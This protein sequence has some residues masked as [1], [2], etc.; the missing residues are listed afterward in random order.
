MVKRPISNFYNIITKK[1][2]VVDVYNLTDEHDV[3]CLDMHM[4]SSIILKSVLPKLKNAKKI[5]LLSGASWNKSS[6]DIDIDYEL[7]PYSHWLYAWIGIADKAPYYKFEPKPH[8]FCSL[9]GK[10]RWPREMF[11]ASILKKFPTKDY[12][13]NYKGKILAQDSTLLDNITLSEKEVV[14]KQGLNLPFD[15]LNSCNFNLICETDV[16]QLDFF[17]TEKT[18]RSLA[19]GQPF[20]VYGPY[21]FNKGLQQLGFK[22]YENLYDTNFDNIASYTLRA[23]ALLKRASKLFELDWSKHTWQLQDIQAHN[24]DVF[25]NQLEKQ[26]DKE[27]DHCEK[28]LN[29]V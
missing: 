7:I 24:R 25:A 18:L 2:P 29:T 27:L 21:N 16:T 9:I 11:V 3:F 17:V 12:I 20:I 14:H 10:D 8:K 5:F 26:Y 19:I 6:F 28:L 13:L 23:E 4:E 15:L 22:T 1:L